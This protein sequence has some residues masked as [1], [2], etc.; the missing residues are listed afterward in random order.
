MSTITSVRSSTYEGSSLGENAPIFQDLPLIDRI[1]RLTVIELRNSDKQVVNE[2]VYRWCRILTRA[3]KKS[4]DPTGP[5]DT[6]IQQT[7]KVLILD[8]TA[9]TN[10]IR[11]ATVLKRDDRRLRM[12]G[13]AR[14]C[15]INSTYATLNSHIGRQAHISPALR[16][17]VIYQ[18]EFYIIKTLDLIK[19]FIQVTKCQVLFVVPKLDRSEYDILNLTT[20][21][22]ILKCD[23]CIKRNQIVAAPMDA[24]TDTYQ[25]YLNQVYF[26]RKSS[27]R[28]LPDR[29]EGELKEDG[30]NL[31]SPLRTRVKSLDPI[32]EEEQSV[33]KFK[34][35]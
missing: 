14:G 11:I 20:S 18:D 4:I 8:M 12:I 6:A 31:N 2:L 26:Q 5:S 25:T 7:R 3:P 19:E 34:V 29:V 32:K 27:S 9:S 13:I 15:K 33:K 28:T 21:Y 1:T 22:Q 30:L 17:L 24:N 10:P 23:F 35:E 16:L